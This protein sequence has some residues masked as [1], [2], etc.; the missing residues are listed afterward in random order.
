MLHFEGLC[1]KED[2][3][4]S[5]ATKNPFRIPLAA[6]TIKVVAVSFSWNITPFVLAFTRGINQIIEKAIARHHLSHFCL[7]SVFLMP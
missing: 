6:I 5:C 3:A 7:R 2:S 1:T 4:Y